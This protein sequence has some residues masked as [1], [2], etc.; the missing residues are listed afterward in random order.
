MH[1][2]IQV[3]DEFRLSCC[4]ECKIYFYFSNNEDHV[5]KCSGVGDSVAYF[6]NDGNL[7]FDA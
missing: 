2:D 6:L 5:N 4:A 3:D 7:N 1:V